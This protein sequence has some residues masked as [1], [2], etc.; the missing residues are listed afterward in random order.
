MQN[1]IVGLK[2]GNIKEKMLKA[3]Y[4]VL[5]FVDVMMALFFFRFLSSAD[6]S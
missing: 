5:L 4:I 6:A 1:Y 2:E 3:G